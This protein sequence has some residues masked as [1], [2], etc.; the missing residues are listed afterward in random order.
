MRQ[1]PAWLALPDNARR[2]LDRLEVEHASHGGSENGKLV[3]PYRDFVKAGIRRASISRAIRECRALGFVYVTVQG[4]RSISDERWPSQ[5]RLTYALGRG[6][7]PDPT[8]DWRKF[9]TLEA[10]ERAARDAALER[11]VGTQ[12]PSKRKKLDAKTSPEPDAKTLPNR[13]FAG[14]ENEP[15]RPD[16]KTSHLYISTATRHETPMPLQRSQVRA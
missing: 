2:V 12:A 11:N 9:E 15:P 6:D 4:S 5:Y 13:T 7:S 14:R 3:C 16:A 1:S 8:N 10:A